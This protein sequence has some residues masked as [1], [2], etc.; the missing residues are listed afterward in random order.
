M[1]LSA[2][3]GLIL[4]GDHEEPL[5][6]LIEQYAKRPRHPEPLR[7]RMLGRILSASLGVTKVTEHVVALCLDPEVALKQ[8]REVLHLLGRLGDQR[9]RTT[10]EFLAE[11]APRPQLRA[12]ALRLL[13]SDDG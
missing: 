12:L 2:A 13:N 8:Q 9:A 3:G 11:A 4:L 5:E 7:R 1:R 10:L 6:W